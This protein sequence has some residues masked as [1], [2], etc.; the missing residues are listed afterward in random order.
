[1][2][3][4]SHV[5]FLCKQK[6]GVPR[7]ASIGK[8]IPLWGGV[9]RSAGV[10]KEAP[11]HRLLSPPEPE[12]FLSR[13]CEPQRPTPATL[14]LATLG[15]LSGAGSDKLSSLRRRVSIL[16]SKSPRKPEGKTWEEYNK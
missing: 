3:P 8:T 11:S 16:G 9:A 1:V 7:C 2:T 10:V 6:L 5:A 4:S 13:L 15:V 14:P 12:S